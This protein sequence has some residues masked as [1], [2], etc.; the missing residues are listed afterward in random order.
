MKYPVARNITD[1]I[2]VTE[3]FPAII[4]LLSD[5]SLPASD[6]SPDKQQVI[7]AEHDGNIIGCVGIEAY[8]KVALFRS[9]AVSSKYR[10]LDIGKR[11]TGKGMALAFKK[12]FVIFICWQQQPMDFSK[13]KSGKLPI[14][15]MY[16]QI[17]PDHL[18]LQQ[19]VH[20]QQFA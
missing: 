9:L 5:C 19:S 3:D 13:S 11:L 7:L 10:G 16:Q 8:G 6:I 1:R 18:N 17:L 12:A 15:K 2:P 20:P 4:K 14:E